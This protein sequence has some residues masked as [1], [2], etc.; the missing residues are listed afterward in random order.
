MALVPGPAFAD[1]AGAAAARIATPGEHNDL[2]ACWQADPD[3]LT[4]HLTTGTLTAL[5]FGRM[6]AP[7]I[8]TTRTPTAI[9][10]SALLDRSH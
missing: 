8:L 1:H 9:S 7:D 5:D 4:R 3:L 2:N 10:A 6:L